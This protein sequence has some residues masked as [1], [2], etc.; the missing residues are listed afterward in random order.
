MLCSP[1]DC[2]A[3]EFAGDVTVSLRNLC[4]IGALHPHVVAKGCPILLNC[5]I[6][7]KI[8]LSLALHVGEGFG[9]HA[10]AVVLLHLSFLL[11]KS[12][13][14]GSSR[15]L[16]HP[17]YSRGQLIPGLIRYN[18]VSLSRMARS[19]IRTCSCYANTKMQVHYRHLNEALLPW[20]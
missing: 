8:V 14:A 17:C 3:L 6:T 16:K 13:T 11:G 7:S 10:E 19:Q 12:T 4:T 15:C 5:C 1:H 2:H 20:T 18:A 9:P